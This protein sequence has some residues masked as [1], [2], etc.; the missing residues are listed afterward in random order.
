MHSDLKQ[1]LQTMDHTGRRTL[2]SSSIDTGSDDEDDLQ[3][4]DNDGK[5]SDIKDSDGDAK[6][7]QPGASDYEDAVEAH[8]GKLKIL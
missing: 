8:T 3:E 1:E 6:T 4:D 7:S 2:G 5:A